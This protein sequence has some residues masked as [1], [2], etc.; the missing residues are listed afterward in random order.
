MGDCL[1]QGIPSRFVTSP[2]S[3]LSLASP[4]SLNL[5]SASAGV[6]AGMLPLSGWHETLSDP[7]RHVSS[8][9]GVAVS[10]T[11]IP[12]S[13]STLLPLHRFVFIL[14]TAAYH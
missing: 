9:S 11:A 3:Q 4:G 7:M 1:R 10:L 14:C 13:C 12:G 5:A 8:R 6:K 2:L